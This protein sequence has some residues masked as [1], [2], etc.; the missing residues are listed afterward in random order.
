MKHRIRSAGLVVREDAI[1]LVAH[2]S[3][4]AEQ[5]IW[6]PPGG[7]VERQ[8]ESI[9]ACAAREIFE[10]TGLTASL[11]RIAYVGEFYD[12]PSDT[13]SCE[14]FCVVDS[15]SGTPTI[16]HLPPTAPDSDWIT[17]LRW[18][19]QNELDSIMVYP[20]EL[21]DRFWQDLSDGFPTVQYLGLRSRE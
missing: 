13:R 4:I 16:E 8:D 1:L 2:T 15:F 20:E 9:F 19:K 12:A 18:F 5:T 3:L 11:S 10:E 7:G 17:E 21:R 6:I 14:F